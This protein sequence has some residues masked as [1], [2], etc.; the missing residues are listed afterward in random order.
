MS[1]LLLKLTFP[2]IEA[3]FR[4]SAQSADPSDGGRWIPSLVLR[5]SE[6]ASE[7]LNFFKRQAP[8]LIHV[9]RFKNSFVAGLE[10]VE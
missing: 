3:P 7:V 2:R 8:V 5:S 10:L 6:R 4:L 9:H 1:A